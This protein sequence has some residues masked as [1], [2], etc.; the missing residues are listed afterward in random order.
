M[1]T[2]KKDGY[3]GMYVSNKVCVKTVSF[4][5]L[6][7]RVVYSKDKSRQIVLNYTQ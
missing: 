4:I 5:N 1:K 6:G 3:L 7:F 2:P